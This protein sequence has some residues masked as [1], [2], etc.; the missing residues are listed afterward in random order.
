VSDRGEHTDS[1]A[2][3][4]HHIV[5]DAHDLLGL[6]RFWAQAL[7]WPIL[8]ERAREVVI[9]PDETAPI[10]M[11]FMPVPERSWA[12]EVATMTEERVAKTPR[13]PAAAF[14]SRAGRWLDRVL[15]R[16]MMAKHWGRMAGSER[17]NVGQVARPGDS[18]RTPTMP[19]M[20]VGAR[21]DPK[22]QES[23]VMRR[24]S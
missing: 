3:R 10:G 15:R 17:P 22:I 12:K 5:V 11:C 16:S 23:V 14:A 9:G 2:V 13:L 20:F 7:G 4:L 19:A 21:T 6:A 8:S 24:R 18:N 1:M